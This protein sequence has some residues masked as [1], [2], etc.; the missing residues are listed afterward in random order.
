VTPLVIDVAQEVVAADGY[1]ATGQ[2][3][4]F[5]AVLALDHA[6]GSVLTAEKLSG[7]RPWDA[8]SPASVGKEVARHLAHTVA[9]QYIEAR[10]ATRAWSLST[11]PAAPELLP[12]P[13]FVRAWLDSRRP[14]TPTA[15]AL[16]NLAAAT[17]AFRDGRHEEVLEILSDNQDH[18][19]LAAWRDTLRART[20][21]RLGDVDTPEAILDKWRAQQVGS[22]TARA[23]VA[24]LQAAVAYRDRCFGDRASLTHLRRL[25]ARLE[26][27]GDIAT[28][29]VV[30][31][32]LGV[33]ERRAGDPASAVRTLQRAAGHLG[34][35]GDL[36]SLQAALFNLAIALDSVARTRATSRPPEAAAAL[37][38]GIQLAQ[39]CEVARDSAQS[40]VTAAKW[41][42]ERD[43]QQAAI[44]WLGRAET[45]V[46][47]IE[48]EAESAYFHFVRGLCADRWPDSFPPAGGEFARARRLFAAVGDV[49]AVKQVRRAAARL[50]HSRNEKAGSRK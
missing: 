5:W 30:L 28:L 16:I 8:K 12:S 20:A 39:I 44:T 29:G 27:T 18:D 19:D 43:D 46:A 15:A 36:Y 13:Q 4:V 48:S 25:A 31:N 49:D 6:D 45:L 47:G 50:G 23:V 3:V 33:A 37:E 40:E 11:S 35:V 32:V 14:A 34:L 26:E 1:R 38:A 41:A 17:I 7:L 21:A 10:R 22:P 9:G 2:W 24:R 42:L